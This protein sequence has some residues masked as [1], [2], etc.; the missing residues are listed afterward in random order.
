M[1][2]GTRQD[3]GPRTF[4]EVGYILSEIRDDIKEL[5]DSQKEFRDAQKRI[6]VTLVT[7][8]LCPLIVGGVLAFIFNKGV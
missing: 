2:Q 1:A 7:S 5:K 3:D 6:T 8:V 4:R